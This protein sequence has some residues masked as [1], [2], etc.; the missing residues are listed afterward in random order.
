[1]TPKQLHNTITLARIG[2]AQVAADRAQSE[3]AIAEISAD[4]VAVKVWAKAFAEQKPQDA[5]G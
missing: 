3:E 2:L 1:M 5:K 4:V